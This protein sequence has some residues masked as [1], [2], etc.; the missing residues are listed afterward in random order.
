MEAA[1]PALACDHTY[2]SGE[3]DA[4]GDGPKLSALAEEASPAAR[5]E[6]LRR[7]ARIIGRI[8]RRWLRSL[9]YRL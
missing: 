5:F 1:I 7:R 8:I 2:V 3:Q 4:R 6:K 9:R